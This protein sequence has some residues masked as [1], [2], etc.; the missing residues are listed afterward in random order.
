MPDG[1]LLD[2]LAR[3]ALAIREMADGLLHI[4]TAIKQNQQTD[5]EAEAVKGKIKTFDGEV[6]KP[7]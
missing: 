2:A 6:K 7:A 5:P 1:V 4:V 3:Q